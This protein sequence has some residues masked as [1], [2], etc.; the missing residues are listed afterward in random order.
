MEKNKKPEE[1]SWKR[2]VG[3]GMLLFWTIISTKLFFFTSSSDISAYESAYNGMSLILVP[4]ALSA[5]ILHKPIKTFGN[6]QLMKNYNRF[7]LHPDTGE[8]YSDY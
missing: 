8:D 4:S 3:G 5:F 7:P 2:E 6:H 1:K